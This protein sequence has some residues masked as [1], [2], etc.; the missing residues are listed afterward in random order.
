MEVAVVFMLTAPSRPRC[1]RPGVQGGTAEGHGSFR[2]WIWREVFRS[3]VCECL[4]HLSLPL[5]F[6]AFCQ[7]QRRLC[8]GAATL[9]YGHAST[10]LVQVHYQAKPWTKEA[11]FSVNSWPQTSLRWTWGMLELEVFDFLSQQRRE[12]GGNLPMVS[13]ALLWKFPWLN[14][15]PLVHR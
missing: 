15:V 8:W 5:F 7:D 1:Q 11:L 13:E 3:L 12:C 4:V 9:L 14:S 10:S 2:S 6:F